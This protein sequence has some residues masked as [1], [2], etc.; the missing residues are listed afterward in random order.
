MKRL[1]ENKL[2]S[3]DKQMDSRSWKVDP[4]RQVLVNLWLAK[5]Q[6][7]TEARGKVENSIQRQLP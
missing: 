4:I 6:G 1:S 2:S 3:M 5:P 7:S